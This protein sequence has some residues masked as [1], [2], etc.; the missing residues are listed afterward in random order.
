MNE[1]SFNI[2]GFGDDAVQKESMENPLWH[3]TYTN[4]DISDRPKIFEC[5]ADN[6]EEADR[7]YAEKMGINPDR[8]NHIGCSFV[9]K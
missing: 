4:N 8:Q 9:K 1:G 7:Q 2:E 3:Y 6:I 5:D